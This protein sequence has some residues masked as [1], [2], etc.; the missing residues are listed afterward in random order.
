M[1]YKSSIIIAP[2]NWGLSD[3]VL[4]FTPQRKENLFGAK[5]GHG[6]VHNLNAGFQRFSRASSS[7]ISSRTVKPRAEHVSPLDNDI[8][9]T[10]P[11]APT[12]FTF[13][14]M[15]QLIF[16]TGGTG[17]IG[18]HVVDQLLK[19]GYRVRAAARS[20]EKQKAL[21]P[22]APNLEVVEIESITSDV[23]QSLKGVDAVIHM[24]AKVFSGGASSEDIFDAAYNGTL[25]IV[26]QSINAGIKKVVITGTFATQFELA[27]GTEPINEESFLPVTLEAFDSTKPPPQVY[28]E[29]KTLAESKVWEFAKENPGIDFTVCTVLPPAV[30]G[31]LVANY[32]ISNSSAHAAIG[33]NASLFRMI[34][35]GTGEYPALFLGHLAD[36]RD[37]ARA[38]V[39]ALS[40]PPITGRN[41]RFIINNKTFKLKEVADLIR[42]E[43]PEL[44]HR[45][46]KE[47]AVPPR[48]TQAPLDTRFAAEVL[49]LKEY[50]FWEETILAGIDAGV[51][52]KPPPKGKRTPEGLVWGNSLDDFFWIRRIPGLNVMTVYSRSMIQELG[53]NAA[54]VEHPAED[55]NPVMLN[56]WPLLKLPPSPEEPDLVEREKVGKGAG[57][58]ISLENGVAA[59]EPSKDAEVEIPKQTDEMEVNGVDDA[60]KSGHC[61]QLS[62]STLNN[63]DS[64]EGL[65]EKPEDGVVSAEGDVEA[66]IPEQ[67]DTMDIDGT[68]GV[69]KNICSHSPQST[70]NDSNPVEDSPQKLD[71]DT[72]ELAGDAKAGEDKLVEESSDPKETSAVPHNSNGN[73]NNNHKRRASASADCM[74][75]MKTK[76][77]H[78][79]NG[80]DK[81]GGKNTGPDADMKV[82][83]NDKYQSTVKAEEGQEARIE[84][85][86]SGTDIE[87]KVDDIAKDQIAVKTEAE[88]LIENTT[89]GTG[90]DSSGTDIEMKV[91]DIDKDQNAVK[92][93]AEARI[94]NTTD[95]TGDNIGDT[96]RMKV[97]N[98]NDQSAVNTEE[99]PIVNATGDV[100]DAT[101]M[102]DHDAKDMKAE[103]AP[104][105]NGT[106]DVG[107]PEKDDGGGGEVLVEAEDK[108]RVTTQTEEVSKTDDAPE[109]HK[110]EVPAK[111]LPELP[112]VEVKSDIK[113]GEDGKEQVKEIKPAEPTINDLSLAEEKVFK[114]K[115]ITDY[116]ALCKLEEKIP[117]CHFPD[118]LI[119]NDP[120][121][122]TSIDF[123]YRCNN[124]R[125]HDHQ[126]FMEKPLRYKRVWP[127]LVRDTEPSTRFNTDIHSSS[128]FDHT[129]TSNEVRDQSHRRIALLNL[130]CAPKLG[131]GHHSLVLKGALNL[132]EPLGNLSE[133]PYVSVAAKLAFTQG[134]EKELIEQEGRVYSS[135]P[136]H[137]QESYSGYNLI[138]PITHPLP[139]SACV[140]KFFGYYVP[141][142][143]EHE[144]EMR[145]NDRLAMEKRK[146]AKKE[147]KRKGLADARRKYAEMLKKAVSDAGADSTSDASSDSSSDASSD[148]TSDSR[149]RDVGMEG[150]E[151]NKNEDEGEDESDD[152]APAALA[153][154]DNEKR[155][156]G[157]SSPLLLV[158]ECGSEIEPSD[159]SDDDRN[160]CLSILFRF[161]HANIAHNSFYTRNFL[162][163][164]GPLT[165]PIQ[166]RSMETPTFRLID[167]GRTEIWKHKIAALL[168]TTG[169]DIRQRINISVGSWS[170]DNHVCTKEE[171][172]KKLKDEEEDKQSKLQSAAARWF[173][174]L[175]WEMIRAFRELNISSYGS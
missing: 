99:A 11:S 27:F 42:K 8:D 120:E 137:L 153:Q 74:C 105:E 50:I 37:I 21:F 59:N 60:S 20:V 133:S 75:C 141:V 168:D 143:E 121:K 101:E 171:H 68:D 122:L 18:S 62:Q 26:R 24:A 117:E 3:I 6:M 5:E 35:H 40:A 10:R 136:D 79:D 127:K 48:Q 2:Q 109:L 25:E 89:G 165:K 30:Y 31:P 73:G 72:V 173:E 92:A 103:D 169:M 148:S 34:T 160:Q 47:D 28:Q 130:S 155:R 154:L 166:E 38:H 19:K 164:P 29:S 106:G 12:S 15:R 131:T 113:L 138:P 61:P 142:D 83:H 23:S 157:P 80:I 98:D 9:S 13:F 67:A 33:T 167:F 149:S 57:S 49:G 44:A 91:E 135:F 71:D 66:E 97:D 150:I 108:A 22:D 102:K 93:E 53:E 100:G 55:S 111:N 107:A 76:K 41:K 119:V 118:I 129:P 95:G 78:I 163:Q 69:S 147:R 156:W 146:K 43:R 140:P 125:R 90:D 152:E 145:E 112:S 36:V 84:N 128:V 126:M 134:S 39:S 87:M 45:L 115:C 124:L 77:A 63:A 175:N 54:G 116:N 56:P 70:S 46:P 144:A 110:K 58:A 114:N 88:A 104:I 32:P 162:S 16:V 82:D 123:D 86:V 159:F 7:T 4:A 17:F 14:Q 172:E 65:P 161:H 96:A 151:E 174:T 52:S 51:R 64:V 1:I 132:P 94:E 81:V 139:A 158:E 170:P 85:G